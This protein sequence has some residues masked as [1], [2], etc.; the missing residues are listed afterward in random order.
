MTDDYEAK[1][2]GAGAVVVHRERAHGRPWWHALFAASAA[3]LIA[4]PLFAGAPV[5]AALPGVAILAA[6]WA[7]LTVLRVAVTTRAVHVQLGPFGPTI[8][9]AAIESVDVA[10]VHLLWHGYGVHRTLDG[11]WCY[12]LPTATKKAVR[13][14]WRDA[15]GRRKKTLVS[16]ETPDVLRDAILR[17]RAGVDLAAVREEHGVADAPADADEAEVVH[18]ETVTRSRG[19]P[20]A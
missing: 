10:G 19:G 5:W 15:R 16:S 8:P 6:S 12:T 20:P 7:M 18:A 14:V 1:Y 2:M 9:L 3:G 11:M 4:A 17:A 13:V